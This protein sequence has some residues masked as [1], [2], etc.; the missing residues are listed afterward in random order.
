MR[1]QFTL[2]LVV[3]TSMTFGCSN[4]TPRARSGEDVESSPARATDEAQQDEK[5]NSDKLQLVAGF[6]GPMPTGVAVSKSGRIF[7]NF[8]RWGDP[9]QYTVAEVKN[10]QAAA[11][12]N[13]EMNKA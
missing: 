10:G 11:Y 1:R 12:P 13:M 3:V 6:W 7:V 4:D 8:P 2:V 5:V 9:V